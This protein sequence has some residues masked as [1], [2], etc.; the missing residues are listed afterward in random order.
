MIKRIVSHMPPGNLGSWL[1]ICL[2]K[3]L[4]PQAQIEN[5]HP[6]E[7]P[8]EYLS[9][10]D[11]CLVD[12]GMRYEPEVNNFDHHQN[13]EL[14]SSVI[15]V[16]RHFYPQV[17]TSARFL[18]AIDTI[19]RFGFKTALQQGLVRGDKST[20]EKR[21]VLLLTEITPQVA[22]LVSQAVKFAAK[23]NASYESFIEFLYSL[24]LHT[25]EFQRAKEKRP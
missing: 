25:E 9:R 20:D 22:L 5:I 4:Y 13:S 14:S 6:Q 12:V 24:L 15:L 7:I 8:E 11:I 16:L 23:M 10:K 19:D 18:Q 21:K 17:D 3:A 2:L 1:A